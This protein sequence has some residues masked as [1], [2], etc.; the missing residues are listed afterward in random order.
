MYIWR[1]YV[2]R[3]ECGNPPTSSFH[4][5]QA[6]LEVRLKEKEE[7]LQF[8]K[9]QAERE[10]KH[11]ERVKEE[12]ENEELCILYVFNNDFAIWFASYHTCRSTESSWNWRGK[13]WRQSWKWKRR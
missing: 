5:A 7:E 6:D 9:Q 10:K 3:L 8:L 13:S 11:A 4:H 2:V 12:A 1:E